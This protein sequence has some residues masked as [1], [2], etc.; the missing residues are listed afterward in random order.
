MTFK[1]EKEMQERISQYAREFGGLRGIIKKTNFTK[2]KSLEEDTIIDSYKYCLS[3][4]S[5]TVLISEEENISLFKKEQL[6]PD[7]LL[8]DIGGESFVI[9]ELKNAANATRQAGTELGAY[10]NA[11]KS[12]FPL[13]ADSDV[14]FIVISSSWP[15]LLKNYLFNEM[16]WHKRKILCLEPSINDEYLQLECFEPKLLI[17]KKLNKKFNSKSFS[18][19]QYCIYGKDIYSGG[20][21]EDLDN[22]IEQ[23]KAS[24]E[25]IVRTST[26]NNSHG[27]AFLWRDFRYQTIARYSITFVDINPFDKF[28]QNTVELEN[29]FTETLNSCFQ[30]NEV[31]GNT[32]STMAS[33]Q[34]GGSFLKNIANPFAEGSLPWITLKGFMLENS[35]LISFKSWG[36]LVDMYDEFFV[37]HYKSTGLDTRY[38][39]AKMGLLF[40]NTIID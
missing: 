39:C 11:L 28:Y 22:N 18:G 20:E 4:L 33:V 37:E 1:N 38:D 5:E 40:T 10:S 23:I 12:H 30:E 17:N 9:V 14:I 16:F 19:Y 26:Q 24:F 8:F 3:L 7:F 21:V 6:K 2:G 34:S 35:E 27:F 32:N 13:I 29:K 31:T 15:T 25:K 36:I